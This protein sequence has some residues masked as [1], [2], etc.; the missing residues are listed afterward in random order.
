MQ[1]GELHPLVKPRPANVQKEHQQLTLL[2]AKYCY[3]DRPLPELVS[4]CAFRFVPTANRGRMTVNVEEVRR[5]VGWCGKVVWWFRGGGVVVVWWWCG[6]MWWWCGGAAVVV[7][8]GVVLVWSGVVVVW[9]GVV[10]AWR[11][12]ARVC[13]A[14]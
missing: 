3:Q 5:G 10:A 1:D 2:P 9:S 13:D 14:W 7:W 12:R 6:V 4:C 11:W 8:S